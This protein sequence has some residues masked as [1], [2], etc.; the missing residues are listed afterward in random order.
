MKD[1]EVLGH[2]GHLNRL[3]SLG[4]KKIQR[5]LFIDKIKCAARSNVHSIAGGAIDRILVRSIV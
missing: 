4:N 1:S 3:P 2:R 5:V